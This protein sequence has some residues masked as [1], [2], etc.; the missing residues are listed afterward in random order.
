MWVGASETVSKPGTILGIGVGIGI[1]I[2]FYGRHNKQALN[3]STPIPTPTPI[4]TAHRQHPIDSISQKQFCDSLFS[5]DPHD[6][7]VH[8][9]GDAFEEHGC[10]LNPLSCILYAKLREVRRRNYGAI[11]ERRYIG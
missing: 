8:A 3:F 7:Q 2:G 5:P 4:C 1:G 9:D 10:T 6:F 11:K